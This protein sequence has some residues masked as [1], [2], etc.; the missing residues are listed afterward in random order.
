MAYSKPI[1]VTRCGGPEEIIHDDISGKVVP[2]K[3]A[4]AIAN[5]IIDFINDMERA[6]LLG[7]SAKS[8]LLKYLTVEVTVDKIFKVYESLLMD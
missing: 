1:I 8:H 3:N 5:A 4:E 2:I 6:K 7:Q